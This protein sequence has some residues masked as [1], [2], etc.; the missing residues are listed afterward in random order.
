MDGISQQ[1]YWSGLP[2]PSPGDLSNPGIDPASPALAGGFF[3]REAQD[4]KQKAY[5]IKFMFS[6]DCCDSRRKSW[7]GSLWRT[8]APKLSYYSNR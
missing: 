8:E 7:R 1:E 6:K 4:F 5:M 3:T 2:F